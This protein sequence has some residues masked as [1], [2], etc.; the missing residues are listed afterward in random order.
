MDGLE[1][2]QYLRA[3]RELA[4]SYDSGHRFIA[5]DIC[6]MHRAWIGDVYEWAGKYRQVNISKGAFTFAAASQIPHLMEVFSNGPLRD[7]TPCRPASAVQL[8]SSLAVVH[9]ELVIIHPFREGN[10]RIA[11]LLA[12][13]M[14][15]QAGLPP[16]DFTGLKGSK[17]QEYFA[18]VRAGM[19]YNYE[20]MQKV[21]SEVLKRTLRLDG[22]KRTLRLDGA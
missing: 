12:A 21:F 19:D 6:F 17:R 8:I 16:L 3:L 10:G 9:T 15:L 22:L 13:L 4:D 5:D 20:P 11:R 7:N 14:A 2:R 18:A 1:A